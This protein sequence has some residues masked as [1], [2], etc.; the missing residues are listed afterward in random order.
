ML[1][2]VKEEAEKRCLSV[3]DEIKNGTFTVSGAETEFSDSPSAK[4]PALRLTSPYGIAKLRGKI[5]RIDECEEDLFGEKVKYARIVDYKTGSVD[6]KDSDESLYSGRSIQLYLYLNVLTRAG[7]RPAGAYYY[8]VDD[9]FT[10]KGEDGTG[11]FGKGIR[12]VSV[13]QENGLYRC[14]R[15]GRKQNVFVQDGVDKETGEIIVKKSKNVL[16]EKDLASYVRYA[17]KS[18][19]KRRRRDDA[20]F[21]RRFALRR[22]LHVL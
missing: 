18:R 2:L 9:S 13:M 16:D 1:N 15:R 17:K 12:N 5:D 21:Y 10:A 14:G 19:G 22:N 4:Y 20:R 8:K 7:Y 3:Y 11:Y 6:N